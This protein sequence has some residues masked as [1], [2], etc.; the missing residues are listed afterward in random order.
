MDK[1]PQIKIE[2]INIQIGCILKV[3]RLKKNLSQ[4]D[5][6]LTLDTNPTSIGRIERAEV[7]SGWD[8][9][10]RLAEE[11]KID[12]A[13]LF[14]LQ[15]KNHLLRLIEEIIH[16]EEKLTWEKEKYYSNLKQ[17]IKEKFSK[18]SSLE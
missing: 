6:A 17:E 3:A 8:K 11:L 10:F 9:I 12:F 18:L 7:I 14:S 1:S 4:H 16:L 5:L 2:L 13:T 15:S